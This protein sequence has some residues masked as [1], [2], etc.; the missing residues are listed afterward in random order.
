ML[1]GS[2]ASEVSAPVDLLHETQ[3]VRLVRMLETFENVVELL[4]KTCIISMYMHMYMHICNM[5]MHMY[6]CMYICI[7][8]YIYILRML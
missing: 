2:K 5:Y 8:V 7:Y 4:Y 1:S 3:F 6:I